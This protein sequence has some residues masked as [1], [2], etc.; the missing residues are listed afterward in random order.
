[1][2][3]V[4]ACGQNEKTE[5]KFGLSIWK[6]KFSFRISFKQKKRVATSCICICICIRCIFYFIIINLWLLCVCVCACVRAILMKKQIIQ[7]SN[8][9][10]QQT[11][12]QKNLKNERMNNKILTLTFFFSCWLKMDCRKYHELWFDCWSS[13]CLFWKKL[14]SVWVM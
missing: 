13:L 9:H 8:T 12:K 7:P 10:T 4:C 1:M 3:C 5:K 11:N 14:M 2:S 6:K